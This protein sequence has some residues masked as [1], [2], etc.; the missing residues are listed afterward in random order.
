MQLSNL[1][2]KNLSGKAVTSESFLH[3]D[4]LKKQNFRIAKQ[5]SQK[6]AI[7]DFLPKQLVANYQDISK[8]KCSHNIIERNGINKD[9]NNDFLHDMK[10]KSLTIYPTRQSLQ[11]IPG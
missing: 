11:A 5:L 8:S 1:S 10:K 9:K 6:N 7:I 4:I 3:V 2:E